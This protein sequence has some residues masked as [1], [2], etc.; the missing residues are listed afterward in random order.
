MRIKDHRRT[1]GHPL[2]FPWTITLIQKLHGTLGTFF[3]NILA[4]VVLGVK[5]TGLSDVE[6]LPA[7]QFCSQPAENMSILSHI[8][9]RTET[10]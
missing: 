3:D 9:F 5:D 4:Q 2:S 6:N 10:D 1:L 8:L 7:L